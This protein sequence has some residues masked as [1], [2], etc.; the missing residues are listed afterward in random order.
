M[1]LPVNPVSKEEAIGK[2]VEELI[3]AIQEATAAS[4]PKRLTRADP[5]PPLP[6]SIQDEIRLK[7]RLRRK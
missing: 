6:A 1:R 2:C 3:S 4:A 7:Y 5:R